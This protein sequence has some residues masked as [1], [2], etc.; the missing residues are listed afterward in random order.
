MT[1]MIQYVSIN[2][3]H[4]AQPLCFSS[5]TNYSG[6]DIFSGPHTYT[7]SNDDIWYIISSVSWM[8]FHFLC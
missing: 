2:Q 1:L 4:T 8:L 5:Q 3:K 6:S 7:A